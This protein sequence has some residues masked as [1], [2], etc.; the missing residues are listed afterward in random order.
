MST[1]MVGDVTQRWNGCRSM[2]L[3]P[4]MCRSLGLE[5]AGVGFGDYN[6]PS[7]LVGW[8]RCLDFVSLCYETT[9]A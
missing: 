9:L 5:V 7:F 8:T 6:K 4:T 3:M 2:L 1:R